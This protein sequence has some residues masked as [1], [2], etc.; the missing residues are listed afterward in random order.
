M[1]EPRVLH[2]KALPGMCR[3]ELI[4]MPSREAKG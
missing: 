2:E 4:S 3:E 1:P